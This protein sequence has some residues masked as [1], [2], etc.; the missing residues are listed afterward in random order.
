[1]APTEQGRLQGAIGAIMGFTG[2]IGPSLFAQTFASFIG[3]H[4][5]WHI[6]GAAFLLAAVLLAA[7]ALL[8]WRASRAA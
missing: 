5:A 1:V 3:P 6:P 7:A 8:G 4:R 2:I